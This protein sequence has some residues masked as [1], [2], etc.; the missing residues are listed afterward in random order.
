MK[1]TTKKISGSFSKNSFENLLFSKENFLCF[2]HA[3]ENDS[4]GGYTELAETDQNNFEKQERDFESIDALI[5]QTMKENKYDIKKTLNQAESDPVLNQVNGVEVLVAQTQLKNMSE[6]SKSEL[7][8]IKN[9]A[10]K[11]IPNL[12]SDVEYIRSETSFDAQL[13]DLLNNK[14]NSEQMQTSYIKKLK[15]IFSKSTDKQR[16]L[17]DFF[18]DTLSE[19]PSEMLNNCQKMLS[20]LSLFLS[21]LHTKNLEKNSEE[22]KEFIELEKP[23]IGILLEKIKSEFES[24]N[25]KE[26]EIKKYN[27]LLEAF[28]KIKSHRN[29]Y[30]FRENKEIFA[31]INDLLK[32]KTKNFEDA[33]AIENIELQ[34]KFARNYKE[35]IETLIT[36]GLDDSEKLEILLSAIPVLRKQDKSIE[37]EENSKTNTFL[38]TDTPFNNNQV[39][40]SYLK[41]LALIKNKIFLPE[42]SEK[43]KKREEELFKFFDEL[44]NEFFN[45]NKLDE[46]F[47]EFKKFVVKN[48]GVFRIFYKYLENRKKAPKLNV[49]LYGFNEKELLGMLFDEEFKTLDRKLKKKQDTAAGKK[50]LS[51]SKKQEIEEMKKALNSK[52]EKTRAKFRNKKEELLGEIATTPGY[53]ASDILKIIS[54]LSPAE[55]NKTTD[56]LFEETLKEDFEISEE[57]TLAYIKNLPKN[58]PLIKSLL[59]KLVNNIDK[60]T[61][62]ELLSKDP[63]QNSK[64]FELKQGKQAAEKII[65]ECSKKIKNKEKLKKETGKN[66]D[67]AYFTKDFIKKAKEE[68]GFLDEVSRESISQEDRVSTIERYLKDLFHSKDAIRTTLKEIERESREKTAYP[69]ARLQGLKLIFK[70]IKNTRLV[71]KDSKFIINI[72]EGLEAVEEQIKQNDESKNQDSL[73]KIKKCYEQIETE[74]NKKE[75]KTKRLLPVLEQHNKNSISKLESDLF[76][77]KEEVEN[78]KKVK[79][80][81]EVALAKKQEEYEEAEAKMKSFYKEKKR[82][83]KEKL[84]KL[85]ALIESKYAQTRED[86]VKFISQV[87]RE[88][89]I[90]KL[91]DYFEKIVD[92]LSDTKLAAEK[93]I[94]VF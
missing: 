44:I 26:T 93:V 58:S 27:S 65:K 92:I 85:L 8:K 4:L 14:S 19:H 60:Q 89:H 54:S 50:E 88:Q 66:L 36:E 87:K 79:K 23:L 1:F 40:F 45:S 42:D 31:T 48:H 63:K 72:E 22:H 11:D 82:I 56:K 74:L 29:E 15:E 18:K 71:N 3:L 9:I 2:N 34:C 12:S 68:E 83:V 84:G 25:N 37:R 47:S 78:L 13:F 94:G 86:I 69:R 38:A 6:F 62:E 16:S 39:T 70:Y 77:L 28:S 20:R 90:G 49:F 91:Y 67:N 21:F 75:A 32:S 46:F 24:M 55:H 73:E 35:I 7:D 43:Y 30:F 64:Y 59:D 41:E 10:S 57:E 51:K 52:K 61:E 33:K 17:K 81:N 5:L 53:Q 80:E 76:S